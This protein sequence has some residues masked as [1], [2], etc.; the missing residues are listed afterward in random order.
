MISDRKW[1]VNLTELSF[2]PSELLLAVK[3]LP[4]SLTVDS[5]IMVCLGV[6]FFRFIFVEFVELLEY[7]TISNQTWTAF[8]HYVFRYYFGFLYSLLPFWDS[9]YT[10]THTW[11]CPHTCL[12]VSHRSECLF[13]FSVLQTRQ[14][15]LTYLSVQWFFILVAKI[16]Y[17]AHL[18]NITFYNSRISVCYFLNN[19]Y[20]FIDILLY[21]LDFIFILSFS[22]LDMVP[23]VFLNTF[24][25]A[26]LKFLST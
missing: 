6:D 12:M 5:L 10:H 3:I 8:V 13:I 14:S 24:K 19:F 22:S 9:H 15:L 2:V 4:L 20:L 21:C 11:W 23:Y 16:N 26:D 7:G 18:G 25:I 17:W 1:A